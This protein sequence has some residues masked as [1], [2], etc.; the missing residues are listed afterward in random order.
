MMN[1]GA[2][3]L[4]LMMNWWWYISFM[5]FSHVDQTQGAEGWKRAS[6]GQDGEGRCE[7]G[8]AEGHGRKGGDDEFPI[9]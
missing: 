8:G 4:F 6:Q 7:R 3:I 9:I 2:L 1:G 5:T